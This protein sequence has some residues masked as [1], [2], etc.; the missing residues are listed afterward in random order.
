MGASHISSHVMFAQAH[1]QGGITVAHGA[2]TAMLT[3][4]CVEYIYHEHVHLYTYDLFA[5]KV[6]CA[7]VCCVV[8]CCAVLCC[9]E[10]SNQMNAS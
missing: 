7:V 4:F 3:F 10:S 9:A 2:F 8:L 5:E 1:T 6:C